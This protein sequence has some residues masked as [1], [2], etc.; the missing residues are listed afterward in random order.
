MPG[1]RQR[2]EV[3]ALYVS[4][5]EGVVRFLIA[6]GL[7]PDKAEEAAQEAF[8]RLYGALRDGETIQ[9][10]KAW[11]YKVA[12]NV[13]I[14]TRKRGAGESAFSEALEATVA[15]AELSVEAR[16]IDRELAESFREAMKHLSKRQRVCL[17]L[18][19]QGLRFAEIADVLGIQISTAAEYVRRGIEELK[20]WSRCKR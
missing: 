16:L 12:R 2:Q 18:R 14:N 15:S 1:E 5:R 17:E 8:L 13:A 11:V 9:Q 3:A 19:A 7:D 6:S 20:K 10:P 4:S